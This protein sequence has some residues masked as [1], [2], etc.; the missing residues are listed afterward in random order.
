MTFKALALVPM[1]ALAAACGSNT[2]TPATVVVAPNEPASTLTLRWS[3]DGSTD[4]ASCNQSGVDVIDI[5]IVSPDTG[6]EIQAFQ[7]QC[8]AFSTSITLEPGTYGAR[9]RLV[10]SQGI[11]RTTDVSVP[12]FTLVGGDELVQT[13][14]FPAD[15]FH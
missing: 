4:P 1:L 15:S 6:G 8:A 11:A 13:V 5:S 3:L 14:D 9:A 2:A 7:Q 10:D 12:P